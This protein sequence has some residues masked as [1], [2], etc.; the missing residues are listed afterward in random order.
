ML[1]VVARGILPYTKLG[2]FALERGKADFIAA[3]KVPFED[4]IN[5]YS[6][7]PVRELF[8]LFEWTPSWM[9]ESGDPVIG[10]LASYLGLL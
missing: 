2:C 1:R 9:K 7:F 3:L 4:T 6:V 5:A 8:C 10:D